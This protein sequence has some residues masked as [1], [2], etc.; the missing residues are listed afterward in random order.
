[1]AAASLVALPTAAFAVSGTA[2]ISA[3]SL[4]YTPPTTVAFT[5][6]LAGAD[7]NVTTTQAFDV[8]DATGSGAGWHI[9]ATSTK[10]TVS[11][12][13]LSLTGVTEQAAPSN[14]CDAGAA[15]CTVGT[16]GTVTYPYTLPAATT[17]PTATNMVSA[18]V[19]TGQGNQ[20]S[21]NTMRLSVP[22][23]TFAGTYLSTWTYTLV[24]AP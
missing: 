6:T 4:T 18:A 16:N 24:T 11:G 1:M 5:A 9:T 3:G 21:T 10:F 22:A 13:D 12:H 23:A 19:N 15:G 8:F 17:A 14:V 7:Q 20:T 2:T